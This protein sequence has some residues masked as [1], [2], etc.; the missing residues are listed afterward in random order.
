[1]GSQWT[2]DRSVLTRPASLLTTDPE[3]TEV[4]LLEAG[5]SSEGAEAGAVGSPEG[6]G[7]VAMAV[8]A[9]I[10]EVGAM[11]APETTTAAGV[12]VVDTVTGAQG[13]PT[14]TATTAMGD[15]TRPEGARSMTA[16][17]TS[18]R[19]TQGRSQRQRPGRPDP[20]RWPGVC[21]GAAGRRRGRRRGQRSGACAGGARVS[22]KPV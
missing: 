6:E 18:P 10:P 20:Q 12:R 19:E 8:V 7:T 11:V 14:E 16:E 15:E 3:G 4:A 5:A 2:G 21:G 9:L 22:I 1:M 13:G 17:V